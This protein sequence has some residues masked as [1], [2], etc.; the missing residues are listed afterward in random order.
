MGGHRGFVDA[1]G[2]QSAAE[3]GWQGKKQSLLSRKGSLQG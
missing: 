3:S 2:L 1:G